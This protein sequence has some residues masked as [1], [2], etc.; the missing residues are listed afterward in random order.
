MDY[1]QHRAVLLRR[2]RSCR[3]PPEAS[4]DRIGANGVGRGRRVDAPRG[5]H[6]LRPARRAHLLGE[7]HAPRSVPHVRT[8]RGPVGRAHPCD[9]RWL[10]RNAAASG[11]GEPDVRHRRQ[12]VLHA[13]QIPVGFP[14]RDRLVPPGYLEENGPWLEEGNTAIIAPSGAILAGPV[15]EKEDTLIVDLDLGAVPSGRRHMDPAGHYNRPDIFRLHVDTSARP[16]YVEISDGSIADPAAHPEAEIPPDTELT[17]DH[18]SDAVAVE[19][20]HLDR[21]GLDQ[22]AALTDASGISGST[23]RTPGQFRR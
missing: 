14:H 13:D 11:P 6:A 22:I 21:N 10:D 8:R 12:S 19:S 15:R 20:L 5:R 4:S 17:E 3:A 1:L 7:L 16:A 23:P 18:R 2:R 9:W